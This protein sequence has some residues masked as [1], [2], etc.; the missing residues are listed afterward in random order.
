M[1]EREI[2][3]PHAGRRIPVTN[4]V[5]MIDFP[6]TDIMA[7]ELKDG[8]ESNSD[9]PLENWPVTYTM[10]SGDLEFRYFIVSPDER[11]A[12]RQFLGLNLN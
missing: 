10:R 6:G 7:V 9:L 12:I 3:L 8:W 11:Q 2:P 4:Y 5:A 1:D